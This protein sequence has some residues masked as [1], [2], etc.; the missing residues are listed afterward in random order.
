MGCFYEM[1]TDYLHKVKS[2]GR[3]FRLFEFIGNRVTIIDSIDKISQIN[4]N[5]LFDAILVENKCVNLDFVKN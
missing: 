2:Q 3:T 1:H 5:D 4:K